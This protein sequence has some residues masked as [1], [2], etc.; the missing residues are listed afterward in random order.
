MAS[1]DEREQSR[2]ARRRWITL[3]ETVGVAGLIVAALSLYLGWAGRRAD[4][5]ERRARGATD[6]CD[7]SAGPT[8][9][10]RYVAGAR[11]RQRAR[12]YVELEGSGGDEPVERH[13]ADRFAIHLD[14]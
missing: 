6:H 8:Y 3:G 1:E 14:E 5:A 7:A 12:L 11:C 10:C 4:E 2:Q 9:Q 13:V